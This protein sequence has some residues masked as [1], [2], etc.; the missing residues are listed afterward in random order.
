MAETNFTLVDNTLLLSSME[1]SNSISRR[2]RKESR[3]EVR[4]N[5]RYTNKTQACLLYHPQ[6]DW[7]TGCWEARWHTDHWSLSPIFTSHSQVH[8]Y[9]GITT[10]RRRQTVRLGV[11]RQPLDMAAVQLDRVQKWLWVRTGSLCVNYLK[12]CQRPSL[13]CRNEVADGWQILN[14]PN[15][16]SQ[17]MNIYSSYSQWESKALGEVSEEGNPE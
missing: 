16:R 15:I 8:E 7:P 13:M 17:Q 10:K 14:K 2:W 3:S 11:L 1:T 5:D 4:G 6:L 9:G 12:T